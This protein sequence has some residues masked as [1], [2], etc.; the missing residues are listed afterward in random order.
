MLQKRFFGGLTMTQRVY[1]WMTDARF[2]LEDV[3]GT[4]E[5]LVQSKQLRHQVRFIN[6]PL[7]SLLASAQNGP[8]FAPSSGRCLD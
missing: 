4:R 5:G 2:S 1:E 3:L 7:P 6:P 8:A